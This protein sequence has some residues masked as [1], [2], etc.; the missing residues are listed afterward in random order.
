MRPTLRNGGQ[1]TLYGIPPCRPLLS[2][3]Q[4]QPLPRQIADSRIVHVP[5]SE[6]PPK[7]AHKADGTV[8]MNLR[9]PGQY[10]DAETGL[11]Y[12]YFRY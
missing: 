5:A 12:H 3:G 10:Y 7:P 8:E 9:F 1:E 6:R 11:H 4:G 2:R